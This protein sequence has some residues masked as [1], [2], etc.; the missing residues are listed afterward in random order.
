MAKSVKDVETDL[1]TIFDSAHF[2]MKT[3]V[4]VC[5]EY[6]QKVESDRAKRYYKPKYET[7]EKYNRLVQEAL[8]TN[9]S[10]GSAPGGRRSIDG[11]DDD[12]DTPI[13]TSVLLEPAGADDDPPVAANSR[14]SRQSAGSAPSGLRF[15]E[16][17]AREQQ[18]REVQDA[19]EGDEKKK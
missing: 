8:E 18:G 11:A 14:H 4:E 3:K 1:K 13:G 12:D 7:S 15:I 17:D 5:L 16:W 19:I 10:A 2:L 6:R 9:L